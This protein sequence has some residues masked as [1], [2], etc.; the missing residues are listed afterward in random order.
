MPGSHAGPCGSRTSRE[1]REGS[2]REKVGEITQVCLQ[3][4]P[5]ASPTVAIK[6]FS[7]PIQPPAFSDP[8]RFGLFS[9]V[10]FLEI[11]MHL[12]R[13][14]SFHFHWF[15]CVC[16]VRRLGAVAGTPAQGTL[17]CLQKEL[18]SDSSRKPPPPVPPNPPSFGCVHLSFPRQIIIPTT[19]IS[20][21]TSR[22][23]L[24]NDR[25]F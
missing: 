13:K 17:P 25:I 16:L 23:Y 6:L 1:K 2:G 15:E 11:S 18:G 7:A 8:M 20:F 5:P 22:T 3:A 9:T 10:H 21:V 12:S 14:S 24:R 4:Y 19:S